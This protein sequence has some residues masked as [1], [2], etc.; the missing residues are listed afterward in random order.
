MVMV[1]VMVIWLCC[2]CFVLNSDSTPILT[3]RSDRVSP[4]RRTLEPTNSRNLGPSDPPTLEPSNPLL[5]ESSNPPSLYCRRDQN[6]LEL[7]E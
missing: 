4:N 7:R 1:M 3:I 2:A 5:S 6:V